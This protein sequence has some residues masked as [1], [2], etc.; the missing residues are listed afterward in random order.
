MMVLRSA[1]TLIDAMHRSNQLEE[2][3]CLAADTCIPRRAD[4]F[5]G[6]G[7]R[8]YFA[9]DQFRYG[10]LQFVDVGLQ[11]TVALRIGYAGDLAERI[12]ACLDQLHLAL[13]I[14]CLLLKRPAGLG[15]GL[16]NLILQGIILGLQIAE[17]FGKI[18]LSGAELLSLTLGSLRF[19]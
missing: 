11:A 15:R 4:A 5:D 17:T 9:V 8:F 10:V 7:D 12:P 19:A 6:I 14:F 3:H 18:I 13:N 1:S 16:R 2:H